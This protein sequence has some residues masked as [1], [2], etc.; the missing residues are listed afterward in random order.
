M[1]SPAYAAAAA[2]FAVANLNTLI[3]AGM[4]RERTGSW[5]PNGAGDFWAWSALCRCSD[6]LEA[7][8]CVFPPR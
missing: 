5:T 7:H 6:I 1:S 4:A 3:V 8:R 2:R